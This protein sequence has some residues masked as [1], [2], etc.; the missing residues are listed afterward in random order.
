MMSLRYE[1]KMN[2][3]RDNF[4]GTFGIQYSA[5]VARV[6][7]KYAYIIVLYACNANSVASGGK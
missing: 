3:E 7:I 1:K 5:L 2:L 6:I 4:Q